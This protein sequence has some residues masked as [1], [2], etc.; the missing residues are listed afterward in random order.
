MNSQND[1][2]LSIREVAS[3]LNVAERTIYRLAQNS[4]LPGFKVAG[5][6][7]FMRQRI[8]N[9]VE[10]RKISNAIYK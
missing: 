10:E 4:E 7:R 1:K 5:T 6:W 3:L 8:K 2:V 9:W